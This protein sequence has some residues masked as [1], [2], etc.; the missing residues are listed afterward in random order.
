MVGLRS[1]RVISWN[2]LSNNYSLQ[3]CN[4]CKH[5]NK[6]FYFSLDIAQEVNRSSLS[7]VSEVYTYIHELVL[8]IV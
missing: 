6:A 7:N 5:G 3:I 2:S 4:K 1:P 8:V